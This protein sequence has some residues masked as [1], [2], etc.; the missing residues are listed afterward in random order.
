MPSIRLPQT[1]TVFTQRPYTPK[2][3]DSLLQL[4]KNQTTASGWILLAD[5]PQNALLLFILQN[6][7]YAATAVKGDRFEVL[8]LREYFKNLSS[9]NQPQLSLFAANPILFKC[10]L[11]SAQKQPTLSGTTD[12]MNVEQLLRQVKTNKKEA[13]VSLKRIDELNVFYFLKG[14]LQ[15]AFFALPDGV[16]PD[17]SPEEQFL[18]YAYHASLPDP[19][20]V[21]GYYETKVDP[22]EDSDLPWLEWPG[23]IVDYYMKGR[24]ELVFLAGGETVEKKVLTKSVCTLGRN[25]KSDLIIT[26]TVAS[27]DHAVIREK[28]GYFT[29]EDLKSRNGT[30]VNDKKITSITVLSDGDEIRIG[31]LRIMYVQKSPPPTAKTRDPIEA[32][33]TTLFE[34][35]GGKAETTASYPLPGYEK[36]SGWYLEMTEGKE[37]GTRYPLKEKTIIGRTKTDI[38]TND[39]KTSRHHATIERKKDGYHF[40]DLK[41]TNG[42]M[43]NDKE[44]RTQ[45]IS[46]GDMIRVGDTVFKV[47]EAQ[48]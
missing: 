45:R 26:D 40:T 30:I 42:S 22:A 34:P 9:M 33:E 43:I 10:L 8:S 35:E 38:N 16:S 6:K 3:I 2:V 28:D 48:S 39:P 17:G 19:I 25:P 29:I 44:V 21:Q 27:R 5:D 18:E 31:D 14:E 41:S 7:P 32:L 12:L 23:G 20:T 13:V 36:K 37:A 46:S 15:E 24:P 11:V 1:K 47:I 4:V